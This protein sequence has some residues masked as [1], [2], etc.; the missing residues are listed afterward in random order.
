MGLLERIIASSHLISRNAEADI[1]RIDGFLGRPAIL[2]VRVPKGYRDERLDRRLRQIRTYRE[3]MIL[4]RLRSGG[5]PVPLLYFVSLRDSVLIMEYI[6]GVSLGQLLTRT[7]EDEVSGRYLS[8]MGGVVREMHRLGVVHGDLNL[9]NV[10]VSGDRLWLIDFGLSYW[11]NSP[12]D[13]AV[14][15]DSLRRSLESTVPSLASG[16]FDEFLNSYRESNSYYDEVIRFYSRLRR[17]GRYY[18]ER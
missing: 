16:L 18:A 7:R 12:K 8:I 9:N 13:M 10:I 6:E 14:D 15:L 11:S 5:L 3:A 1:Y 2:K 4:H 17:M